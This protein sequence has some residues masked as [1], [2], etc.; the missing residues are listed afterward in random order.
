MKIYE[1]NG[2][3]E[4]LSLLRGINVGGKNPVKMAALKELYEELGFFQVRTYIQSGNAVF[5]S[6]LSDPVEIGNLISRGIL[7]LFGFKVSCLIRTRKDLIKIIRDNPFPDA[8]P[9]KVLVTFLDG[10]AEE[11]L[12]ETLTA[13]KGASEEFRISDRHIILSCPEGYGRTKLS[14]HFLE[15]KSGC[16]A[17]TRNMKTL[18]RI[19]DLFSPEK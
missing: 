14:N 12:E 2:T 3:G 8:D 17:T 16:P 6:P 15:Q 13:V 18:N 11:D 19:M 9:A 4:Y 1:H 10:R 5:L 7:N